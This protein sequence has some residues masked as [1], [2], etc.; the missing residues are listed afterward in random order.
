MGEGDAPASR[1]PPW[2]H[3]ANKQQRN[4][5]PILTVFKE[6]SGLISTDTHHHRRVDLD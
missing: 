1:R 6:Y 2:H 5:C 3:N 4:M